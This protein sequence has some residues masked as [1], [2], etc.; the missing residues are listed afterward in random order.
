MAFSSFAPSNA[1][2]GDLFT[3]MLSLMDGAVGSVQDGLNNISND[4]RN[5]QGVLDP[6]GMGK[7]QMLMQNYISLV[8]L[9]SSIIKQFGD[10]D[11]SIAQNT[12]S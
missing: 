8:Q 9:W 5:S 7:V 6:I 11:R 2:I 1:N 3:K 10:V 12:G 4:Y